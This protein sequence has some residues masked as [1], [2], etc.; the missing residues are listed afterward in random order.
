[1]DERDGTQNS[2]VKEKIRKDYYRRKRLMLKSE[3]KS[4]NKMAA[5]NTLAVPV[6]TYSFNVINWTIADIDRLDRKIRK[7][8]TIHRMHHPKADVH[9]IYLPRKQG[10][11]GLIQ[12]L[13]AYK[14][15]TIGLELYLREKEDRFLKAVYKHEKYK[16]I[17]SIVKVAE[18]FNKELKAPQGQEKR[19]N[20]QPR[21]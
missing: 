20:Q 16:G 9:R 8:L 14:V 11:T 6:V 4:A 5:I 12:I 19:V 3:V 7:L 2:K 13:A 17:H 1:M 18:R 10:E 21:K 15:S